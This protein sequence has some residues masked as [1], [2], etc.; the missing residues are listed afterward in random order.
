MADPFY[1]SKHWEYPE[2]WG[3]DA[4]VEHALRFALSDYFRFSNGMSH[5]LTQGPAAIFDALHA[6]HELRHDSKETI[7]SSRAAP[8]RPQGSPP[9]AHGRLPGPKKAV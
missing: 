6:L 4:I 3:P 8:E 2:D 5:P 7:L 1:E 9:H